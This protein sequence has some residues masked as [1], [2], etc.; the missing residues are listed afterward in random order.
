[1]P[2]DEAIYSAVSK[3]I[4]TSGE[5]LTLHFHHRVWFEKPPLLMWLT[6]A[7][8]RVL[9]VSEF[10]SRASRF[11]L[12][13]VLWFCCGL[14]RSTNTFDF[15]SEVYARKWAFWQSFKT[16]SSVG[17][18]HGRD[19]GA[20]LLV[21]NDRSNPYAVR[22]AFETG[23]ATRHFSGTICL[24][25]FGSEPYAAAHH[26]EQLIAMKNSK[27]SHNQPSYSR[28]RFLRASQATVAAL[29]AAPL[30][31]SAAFAAAVPG[32][33]VDAQPDYY[34]KLGVTKIINAAGT[35]TELTSA[36]MP[37]PVRAAVAQAAFHPVH[38][39][40]LQQK[41]GAYIAKRLQAEGCCISCGASSAITL[42]TAASV[43]AANN[44]QPLD[45]PSR[46]GTPQ[47]PKNEVVVQKIHRYEYDV[48]MQLCGVKLVDVVTLDDYKKAF[49]PNTVMTNYFNAAE[50][51][52][53]SR[54]DW[55]A[56]AHDKSVPCH[57]DAAADMPPI[58]NLWKYTGMGFD[59]VSFSGGKDIRG[60]QNAGLLL[61]KKKYTDLAQRNLCPMDSVGRGMKIAK[62][63]I[64]GMV[65]AVDWLLTQTDEEMEKESRDRMAVIIAMVK[66]L[67]SVETSVM[68]PELAN[69]VPHL[70][71]TFDPNV[72]GA[73]A[74]ELK[75][76][77]RTATPCI[78]L[79][80]HT[81]S[82]QSS[83]GVPAQPNA[84][85]VTTF[86]LNPGEETIVATQV[87]KVLKDPKSVGTYAPPRATAS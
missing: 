10:W 55:I 49:G 14:I 18:L 9:G 83:Q 17:L 50:E 1:L 47:F 42:A 60:P 85:V 37:P 20:S 74:R 80:P 29:G 21:N 67:P 66:D 72:I 59:M 81:G 61:G 70:M 86:L 45:I 82:K 16:H 43:M 32:D 46:I 6:A 63:Q 39:E 65:A 31:G 54:E 27:T 56:V 51:V 35:Y 53:I 8:Y 19:L 52:G 41:A 71:I 25:T 36:V 5:W 76:R 7:F 38:L 40:E 22:T 69:H 33:S 26:Q 23:G 73:S 30:F 13:K 64:V 34:D 28:R 11:L 44:C 87:Q 4:V 2:W 84:L 77:L 58:S 15:V 3:E 78:E 62:E 57:L 79:N 68:V 75:V 24:V 12:V 48:A